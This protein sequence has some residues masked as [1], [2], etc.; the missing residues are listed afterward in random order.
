MNKNDSFILLSSREMLLEKNK[1]DM[2]FMKLSP[3]EESSQMKNDWNKN[4]SSMFSGALAVVV[5]L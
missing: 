2:P 4:K 3:N 5:T 1:K